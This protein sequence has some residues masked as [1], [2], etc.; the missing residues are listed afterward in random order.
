MIPI[1]E[2]NR[3]VATANRREMLSMAVPLLW[4]IGAGGLCLLLAPTARP[5]VDRWFDPTRAPYV[6]VG[7]AALVLG[8]PAI[9]LMLVTMAIHR[10]WEKHDWRLICPSC[11]EVMTGMRELVVATRNCAHCGNKA[12]FDPD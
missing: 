4:M 12:L 9:T 5:V 7:V 2:Y 6:P 3:A 11:G 8:V 1:D 10:R